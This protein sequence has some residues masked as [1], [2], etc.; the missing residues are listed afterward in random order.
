MVVNIEGELPPT[1]TS[2]FFLLKNIDFSVFHQDQ[3]LTKINLLVSSQSVYLYN[4]RY[5][6][7]S[8]GSNLR[9]LID[10]FMLIITESSFSAV[11]GYDEAD[12]ID[13]PE[14]NLLG[15]V[16]INQLPVFFSRIHGFIAVTPSD[17]ISPLDFANR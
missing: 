16:A 7:S 1:R 12:V 13:L 3:N 10:E 8:P 9:I 6:V 4:H 11:S 14:T 17:A 15:A 5:I 2:S